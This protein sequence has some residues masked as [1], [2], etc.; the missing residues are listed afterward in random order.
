MQLSS[1]DFEKGEIFFI[2]KPLTWTSF[3]VVK[4]MRN[5][6]RIKKIGHAGTL[7][8]LA[9]GLLIVC[10]GKATKKISQYQDMTKVYTG[11]LV[12]GKTTPSVDLETAFDS[13]SDYANVSEPMVH[14]AAIGLT[15]NLMQV[16]PI[17][18]AIKI[19]GERAYKKARRKEDAKLNPRPV[20]V[21]KF[22]ITSTSLPEVSFTIECSKGTYIRS[23]VRDLGEVLGCGAYLAELRRTAIGKYKIEEAMPLEDFINSIDSN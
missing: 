6:L 14:E 3:D 16:P 21:S 23:L 2:D 11:K 22:E 1:F 17:Y 10:A 20:V 9:T 19:D 15:G 12:I 18:S 13:E 5:R 8:P 4:K 7:D